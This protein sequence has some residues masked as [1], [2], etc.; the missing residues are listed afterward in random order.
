MYEFSFAVTVTNIGTSNVQEEIVITIKH[1]GNGI[2]HNDRIAI[3][4][5]KGRLAQGV[6]H[7]NPNYN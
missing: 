3:F 6:D 2:P 7:D 4:Y 5:K 1:T